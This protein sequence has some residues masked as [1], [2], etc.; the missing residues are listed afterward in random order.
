MKSLGLCR[1][2]TLSAASSQSAACLAQA[3]SRRIPGPPSG[4]TKPRWRRCLTLP[5][6]TPLLCGH[7]LKASLSSLR[8]LPEDEAEAADRSGSTSL[9]SPAPEAQLSCSDAR[10]E[11]RRVG[12]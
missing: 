9:C 1:E 3:S 2:R 12:K 6:N 4:S 10:S 7:G 11:E 5:D 8:G